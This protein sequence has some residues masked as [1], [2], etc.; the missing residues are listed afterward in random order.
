MRPESNHH[1]QPKILEG[2]EFMGL[3]PYI[4]FHFLISNQCE[5]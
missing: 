1:S 5:T 3:Y 4:V 2:N